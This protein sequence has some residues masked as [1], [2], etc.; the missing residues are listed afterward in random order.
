MQ[1]ANRGRW[2]TH[3]IRFVIGVIGVNFVGVRGKNLT[4]IMNGLLTCTVLRPNLMTRLWLGK[5]PW[6]VQWKFPDGFAA[7]ISP[8]FAVLHGL[9]FPY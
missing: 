3:K 8:K 2:K 9:N 6:K 5:G 4:S 7:G 1:N